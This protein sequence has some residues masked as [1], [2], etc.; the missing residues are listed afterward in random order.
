MPKMSSELQSAGSLVLVIIRT[1]NDYRRVRELNSS[2]EQ[3]VTIIASFSIAS[4]IICCSVTVFSARTSIYA[5]T[6]FG[7]GFSALAG[8]GRSDSVLVLL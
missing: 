1:C 8:L 7:L 6:I 2:P 4:L 3:Y 5:L